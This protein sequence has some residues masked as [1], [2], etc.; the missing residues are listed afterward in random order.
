MPQWFRLDRPVGVAYLA[1][2]LAGCVKTQPVLAPAGMALTEPA[3]VAQWVARTTPTRGVMHRFTWLYVDEQASKGGRGSVRIAPPD[4]LRFDFAGSLGIGKGTAAVVG[5]SAIWVVPE[6][7]VEELVPGIALL[8]AVLGVAETPPEGA[9]LLGLESE[10]KAAWQ[11]V[12]ADDTVTY[13]RSGSD[14]VTLAAEVRRGGKVVGRTSMTMKADGTPI[15]AR[16]SV[17]SV[18]SKLEIT[19][20]ATVPT[21]AFPPEI[22]ARPIEP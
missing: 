18:P 17:P 14:P 22:W 15:K 4:S 7:S 3:Q 13:V 19:F 6:R 2:G 16:L 5:D 9:R 12:T 21:A 20:Y 1:L 10:G 8:W 11:Y